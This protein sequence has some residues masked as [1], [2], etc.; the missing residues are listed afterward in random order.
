MLLPVLIPAKMGKRLDIK[1]TWLA[2]ALLIS[3]GLAIA[4]M[5]WRPFQPSSVTPN[6]R[7]E[8]AAES[9]GAESFRVNRERLLADLQALSVER[10][11][12]GDRRRAR[13]Y[14]TSALVNA[15]WAVQL[16]PFEAGVNILAERPGSDPAAEKILL[17]A[18]YDSVQQSPGADDN[19]TGVATVLETAR[20]L[21]NSTAPRTL[22]LALFDLEEAGLLGSNAF[23]ADPAQLETLGAAIVLDMVGYSC[24]PAGCQQY[25]A[26]LPIAP[27]SD[28]GL[29]LAGLSDQGH[30]PLLNALQQATRASLPPVI[31]LPI[32]LVGA[33]TPDLVRSDH[34]V[35]W[36]KGIGAVLVTDTANFRNPN[37]HQPTDTFSTVNPDFFI[38]SAQIVVNT[39]HTLLNTQG[40]LAT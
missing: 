25:P 33:L 2:I 11:E 4:G 20:L 31:G 24:D 35:F 27:A 37:Y 12:L 21:A 23:A 10:F 38:G 30:L 8:L 39:I 14:I 15:G 28:R 16:Q 13:D 17:A 5:S 29:F 26:G 19:A 1:R 6:A 3:L 9:S 34:A 18:H 7:Y 40:N 22:Q 32:P 36:D